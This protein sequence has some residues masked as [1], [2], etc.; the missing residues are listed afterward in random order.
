PLEVG[1]QHPTPTFATRQ[2]G[3]TRVLQLLNEARQQTATTL[4]STEFNDTVLAP[5]FN[6]STTIDAMIAR[7]SLINGDLAGALAAA[8]RVPLNVLSEF[9]FASTDPNPLFTMWSNSG[10]PTRMRPEDRFRTG[11]EAG[12][13]RVAFFVTA[14]TANAQSNAGSPLDDFVRYS[15]NIHPFPAYWP[16]EMRLIMAEVHAR[17]NNL[18][19]ALDLLNQVRVPCTSAFDEPIACQPALTLLQVP[20][21]ALMLEAILKERA[22][23]LYLTGLGW[24]DLRRFGKPVKYQFMSVSRTE[25]AG[26]PNVP[27]ELCTPRAP[28]T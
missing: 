8:Q 16:D 7:Y 12:D 6:L 26:N 28:G 2:E 15:S 22:Y 23:E 3:L 9:R 10:N 19:L 11:A 14:S 25:C 24:S 4:P 20:T 1:L 18:L 17:Q 5:G 13:R 21:Q 27:A